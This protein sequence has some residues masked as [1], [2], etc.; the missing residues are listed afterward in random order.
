MLMINGRRSKLETAMFQ[1]PRNAMRPSKEEV[2]PPPIHLGAGWYR[3]GKEKIR[4]K[5]EA[6]SLWEKMKG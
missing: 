5:E 2:L 1:P 3:V 4:G 6:Y